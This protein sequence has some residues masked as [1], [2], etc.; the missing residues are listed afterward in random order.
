M[1]PSVWVCAIVSLDL[2]AS[3]MRSLCMRHRVVSLSL[4][5]CLPTA[6]SRMA[7]LVLPILFANGQLALSQM[8]SRLVNYASPPTFFSVRSAC[9]RQRWAAVCDALYCARLPNDE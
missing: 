7:K 8:G 1:V 9:V 5:I 4:Q 3:G 2:F 6:S